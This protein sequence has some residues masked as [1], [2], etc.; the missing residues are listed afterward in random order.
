MSDETHYLLLA[1]LYFAVFMI[2]GIV[3]GSNLIV[4]PVIGGIL[5]TVLY[6]WA[7][8]LKRRE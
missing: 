1:M 7:V 2:A 3:S 6:F 4:L 5:T 8:F